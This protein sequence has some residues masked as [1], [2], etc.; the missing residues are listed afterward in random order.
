M[1]LKV[2]GLKKSATQGLR[3]HMVVAGVNFEL[4]YGEMVCLMGPSGSG[5]STLFHMLTGVVKSDA[6]QIAYYRDQEQV[7]LDQLTL[8]VVFEDDNLFEDFRVKGNFRMQ[9]LMANMSKGRYKER[10]ELMVKRYGLSA[11]LDDYPENLTE[12]DRKWVSLA[13]VEMLSPDYFFLDD[14]TVAMS[15][16]FKARYLEVIKGLARVAGAFVVTSDVT[17]GSY[18]DR[19]L[20]ISEG[21]I[22]GELT[23]EPSLLLIEREAQLYS[24]LKGKGW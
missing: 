2:E 19:I 10:L 5:Q 18:A 8:G 21:L 1:F 11:V 4:K 22:K 24:W 17:C 3:T 13:K 16:M 20:Y 7:T 9:A 12:M 23:L 6:G 15:P 14:P